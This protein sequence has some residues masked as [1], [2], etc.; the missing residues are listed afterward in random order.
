M[1]CKAVY[2]YKN[3]APRRGGNSVVFT[4]IGPA[5]AR[6]LRGGGVAPFSNLSC[7][8]FGYLFYKTTVANVT[9]VFCCSSFSFLKDCVDYGW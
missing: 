8:K 2:F 3:I 6:I 9:G 5:L 4:Q 1:V 7:K